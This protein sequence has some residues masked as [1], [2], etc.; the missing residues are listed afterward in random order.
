MSGD[1]PGNGG[2]CLQLFD[3]LDNADLVAI[4]G[5]ELMPRFC[6]VTPS[7]RLVGLAN[8]EDLTIDDQEVR[9]AEGVTLFLDIDGR[10][11][12]ARFSVERVLEEAESAP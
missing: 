9:I 6:E 3:A 8:E 10:P 1:A 12:Q 11:H 7:R 2:Y 4:D 5:V